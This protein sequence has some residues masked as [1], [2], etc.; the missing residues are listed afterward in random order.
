MKINVCAV[1]AAA[2]MLFTFSGSCNVRAEGVDIQL[3]VPV[4]WA[5][6][7]QIIDDV[8]YYIGQDLS[9]YGL[10]LQGNIKW[11][12]PPLQ[13]DRFSPLTIDDNG[14]LYL[15]SD[16]AGE[17][18]LYCIGHDNSDFWSVSLGGSDGMTP[19]A[20]VIDDSTLLV[21]NRGKLFTVGSQTRNVSQVE[22]P[23]WRYSATEG[24]SSSTLG[25]LVG[26]Y[27]IRLFSITNTGGMEI[28]GPPTGFKM[29]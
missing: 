7:P 23:D 21:L 6:R 19:R 14:N 10:D 12:S 17:L 8:L 11:T 26:S 20:P 29:Q 15:V 18:I 27:R 1:T 22:A 3:S 9:L 2:F 24:K 5:A 25:M 16:F 13:G 28:V 4:S